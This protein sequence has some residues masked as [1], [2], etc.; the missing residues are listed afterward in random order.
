MYFQWGG[1]MLGKLRIPRAILQGHICSSFEGHGERWEDGSRDLEWGG[2]YKDSSLAKVAVAF[3]IIEDAHWFEGS[4]DDIES[5]PWVF[6]RE[7][8]DCCG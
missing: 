2:V 1:G 5:R 7:L 6:G 4:R 8:Q 3:V